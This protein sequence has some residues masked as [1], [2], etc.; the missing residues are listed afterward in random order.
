MNFEAE[1]TFDELTQ[2]IE[3][4]YTWDNVI[5]P[6]RVKHQ[7]KDICKQIKLM[8]SINKDFSF[9]DKFF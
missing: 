4:T 1:K 3:P 2:K 5:L 9:D 6:I 8:R 7:L